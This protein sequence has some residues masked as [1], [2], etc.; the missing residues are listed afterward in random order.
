MEEH[1]ILC[2]ANRSEF[3]AW[4]EAHHASERECWASVKRGRPLDDKHFWYLDAVEEALCFGWIDSRHK[5]I[6]VLQR[7]KP[8]AC[9]VNGT[10]TAGC[11]TTKFQFIGINKLRQHRICYRSFIE[12]SWGMRKLRSINRSFI[13][14]V[15]P[16]LFICTAFT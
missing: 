3:R 14:Y 10:T 12:F 8:D 13:V 1:N 2:I 15:D 9:L 4:L 16:Y 11:W 5:L 7:P 6:D